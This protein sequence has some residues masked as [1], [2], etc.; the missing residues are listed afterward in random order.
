VKVETEFRSVAHPLLWNTRD[1]LNLFEVVERLELS[2]SVPEDPPSD[3]VREA[4]LELVSCMLR[5]GDGEDVVK[6]FK[7]TLLGLRHQEEDHDERKHV[8]PSVE[9]KG[10]RAA[11]SSEHS[12][13]GEGEDGCPEKAS[14]YSPGHANLTMCEREHLGR[15]SEGYGTFARR[16]EGREQVDEEGD[17][18]GACGRSRRDVE[19][20]SGGE[21]APSHVRECKQQK[22]STP[23]SIDSPDGGEGERE[24]NKTEAKGGEQ[25]RSR[26]VPSIDEDSTRIERNDVDTA[27]LLSNHDDPTRECGPSDSGN[28]E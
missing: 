18:T 24:V 23:E 2:L 14:R 4:F 9:S 7:C 27:H 10:T 17:E 13:E 6:L 21:K 8:E 11:E 19:A 20:E 16:V 26:G 15:V 1:G 22:I 3:E 12:R 28:C 25:S 5:R